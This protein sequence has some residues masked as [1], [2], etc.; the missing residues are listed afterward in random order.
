MIHFINIADNVPATRG[1]SGTHE[2]C[3]DHEAGRSRWEKGGQ[4]H[5]CELATS[6]VNTHATDNRYIIF[7]THKEQWQTSKH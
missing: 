2:S 1:V 3:D 7:F 5:D 4:E 6:F